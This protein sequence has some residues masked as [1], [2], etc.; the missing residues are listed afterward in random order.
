M[1]FVVVLEAIYGD[2]PR[3]A[4]APVRVLLTERD[5]HPIYCGSL[6]E[7]TQYPD[8]ATAED[9]ITRWEDF[10]R[11]VGELRRFVGR[12]WS[13]VPEKDQA[14]IVPD[15]AQGWWEHARDCRAFVIRFRW[16]E[17]WSSVLHR[18]VREGMS[19]MMVLAAWGPPIAVEE[20]EDQ[21][22]WVY[23]PRDRAPVDVTF[24]DGFVARARGIRSAEVEGDWRTPSVGSKA[25]PDD[26]RSEDSWELREYTPF[27][28][29][30]PVRPKPRGGDARPAAP[31]RKDTGLGKGV[32]MLW[33][34]LTGIRKPR[35]PYPPRAVDLEDDKVMRLADRLVGELA[36]RLRE[37]LP[38]QRGEAL[39]ALRALK[40]HPDDYRAAL[41]LACT[42]MASQ[43]PP[44]KALRKALEVAGYMFEWLSTDSNDDHQLYPLMLELGLEAGLRWHV[45]FALE[46]ASQCQIPGDREERSLRLGGLVDPELP[47]TDRWAVYRDRE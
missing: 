13:V 36:I 2:D 5:G 31:A 39:K 18:E 44:R 28:G 40:H 30:L 27:Y 29:G 14:D 37:P 3:W 26:L 38:S 6:A 34:V 10:A 19:P 33:S 43:C 41:V 11:E 25:I 35:I 7:A 46:V 4:Y 47:G 20:E 32:A 12:R 17:G 45:T 24:R 9:A 21:E 23:E 8:R 15:T 42:R 22:V 1:S 16:R